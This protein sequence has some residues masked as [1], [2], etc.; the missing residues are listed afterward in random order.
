V[1]LLQVLAIAVNLQHGRVIGGPVEQRA[2]ET[3]GAEHLGPIRSRLEVL[4][5]QEVGPNRQA[6]VPRSGTGFRHNRPV[7]A[8]RRQA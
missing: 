7:R 5:D 6:S 4:R 1:T 2:S 8:W 3:F